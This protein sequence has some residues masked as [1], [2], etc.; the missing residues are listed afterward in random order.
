MTRNYLRLALVL[1]LIT[2]VG[3]FAIDMYLPA[4]PGIGAALQASPAAVQ[5][6]LTIYFIT[7]G[8]CQPVFG[9]MSDIFGRKAPIYAGLGIFIVG[10][11]GCALAPNIETLIAFR[12]VQALGS[13]AGQVAPRAIVRDL[14]TGAEAAKMMGLLMLVF[15]VSPILAPL[16]GSGIIAVLGWRAVF[17]AITAAAALALFLAVTQL[18]ETRPL[19]LRAASSW[20]TVLANYR[21]L[22]AD[23]A[24]V[25]LAFVSAFGISAFFVYLADASFVIIGHFGLTAAQFSL[26]FALNAVAFIGAGQFAGKISARFG[27][28]RVVRHAVAGFALAMAVLTAAV[29]AGLGGLPLIMA[30][31]F[32][33]YAFLGLVLPTTSV[34]A[35]ERHG[36]KA[37]AASAMLGSIQMITGSLCMAMTAFFSRQ[38]PLPMVAGIAACALASCLIAQIVLRRRPQIPAYHS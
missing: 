35:M 1:G 14:H 3:P 26:C 25:G 16:T 37:G 9:P 7:V 31:L 28:A 15:S 11:I 32:L 4:L 36:D 38:A 17:W 22:L 5:M 10:S 13:C 34:L 24:F 30:L 12:A 20:R 6:T 19:H 29:A 21:V 2:A 27:L 8:A 23:P 33:G 18:K